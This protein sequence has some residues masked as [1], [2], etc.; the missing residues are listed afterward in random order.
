MDDSNFH[1]KLN[2]EIMDD[3]KCP[4]CYQAVHSKSELEYDTKDLIAWYN[5]DI[6]PQCRR[7]APSPRKNAS[8]RERAKL[9]VSSA[10]GQRIDFICSDCGGTEKVKRVN[11]KKCTSCGA[12]VFAS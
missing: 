5:Y 11:Y 4:I 3:L 2:L 1:L 6:C 9:L 12:Y 7:S 8:Y 10:R